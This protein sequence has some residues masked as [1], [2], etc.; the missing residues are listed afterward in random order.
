MVFLPLALFLAFAGTPALAADPREVALGREIAEGAVLPDEITCS[1]CHGVLGIGRP[2]E[3]TPRLAGQPRLYLH[4]Q[5]DDFAAGDRAQRED[6]ARRPGADPG[7]ARGGRRLLCLAAFRPVSSR[8]PMESRRWCR[9]AGCSP[10]S[11]TRNAAFAPARS[12]MPMRVSASRR[13]FRIW[14]ASTPITPQSSCCSGRRARVATTRSRSWP[15]S[16]S[17][18]RRRRFVRSPFTSRASARHWPLSAAPSP[19]SPSRRLRSRLALPD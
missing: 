10:R 1:R 3:Q 12:A 5:L 11:A 14:P 19:R 4:K 2:E 16:P 6:G 17:G 7:A 15:R 9:R 8:R 18:S 13:A